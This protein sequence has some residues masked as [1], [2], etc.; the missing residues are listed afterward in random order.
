[1]LGEATVTQLGDGLMF[2]GRERFL[3]MTSHVVRRCPVDEVF[4]RRFG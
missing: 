4:L 3:E 2:D 1:M